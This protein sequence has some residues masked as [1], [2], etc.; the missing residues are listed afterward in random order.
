MK[1]KNPIFVLLL[2]YFLVGLQTANAQKSKYFPDNCWGVYSWGGWD[3]E[4]VTPQS[5]PLIKGAPIIMRWDELEPEPGKFRFDEVIREKLKLAEKYNYY[6]FLK[7][8]VAPRAPRWLYEHG[9]PELEMTKTIDPFGKPRTGTFQY[10]LD[11]DY[12]SF[13]Y[14]LL[15]EYGKYVL[16]L[17]KNLRERVLYIQSAE[18]STGDGGPY[19]GDPL[20]LKYNITKEQWGDFRIKA[21]E[22][23]K[24]ALSNEKGELVK[25]ILVNYDANGEKEYSWLLNNLPVIGLKNGMFSHGYQ[26]SD[27]KSRVYNWRNFKQQAAEKGIEFFSRGEQ[28]GEWAIYGWSTKNTEQA[29][30]WSGIFATSCGIDMWN[31]PSEASKGY[32][33]KDGINF[34]NKYAGQHNPKTASAAFCALSKGLDASDTI[35]YSA[36]KYG[37]C[38]RNNI[39]RYLKIA[40]AYSKFGAYQGDPAKAIGTGML[41]RK[42]MDYNDVGWGIFDGNLCRFIDQIDAEETSEGWWHIGPHESIYGR[43]ARSIKIKDGKGGIYFD[44][45]DNFAK[46]CK[47]IEIRIVWLDKGLGKWTVF[48]NAEK[49]SE[50]SLLTVKNGNTGK[51]MEKTVVVKDARF[52]NRGER[53]SDIC[54]TTCSNG[55]SVF[56]LLEV[57][58]K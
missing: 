40:E 9:V 43:F 54:I 51:W 12:I 6:T 4:K 25:P 55:I 46:T 15:S 44:L 30:Y 27:T 13:Y 14:R 35:S 31:V 38:L 34:F 41:N 53:N 16:S 18:G 10:Y 36:D 48:Y 28:D 39:D 33:H 52:A 5:H 22:V 17:P 21:W 45:N 3:T 50:K 56:H 29:F 26:I 8:W 11:E 57:T 32:K 20:D 1:I 47:N 49:K 23:L 37:V 2:A 19:K 58:K 7:I 24:K 42:A